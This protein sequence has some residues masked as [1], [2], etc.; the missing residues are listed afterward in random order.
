MIQ[1]LQKA[2]HDLGLGDKEIR[3]FL[4]LLQ[5]SSL[6]VQ[7]IAKKARL[8]RTTTYGILKALGEKG[9]VSSADRKGITE[10][11]SI[12]PQQLLSYIDRKRDRLRERRDEIKAVVPEIK[13]LREKSD[14]L[15]RIR[16]FEGIEGM[17]QAYEDTLEGN[18]SKELLDIT[19]TD[20]I[21]RRMGKEWIEYYVRK[22][23]RLGIQCIDI[24]PDSEWSRRSKES[25]SEFLRRTELLP[26]QYTFDT[27]I[28]IYDNKVGI[29]SFSEDQPLAV[30]IEDNKITAALKTLFRYIESTL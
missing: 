5:E 21:F 14:V 23:A 30:I 22:R 28:D 8:N 6:R 20:A 2:A 24:A 11:Q 15:P 25:D 12:E 3:V 17:K 4:V 7:S 10:Y 27:E 9:L 16:F 29:F 13:K 1:T 19:G 26:E 18:E